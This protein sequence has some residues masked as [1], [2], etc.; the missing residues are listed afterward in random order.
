VISQL[1]FPLM[2]CGVF[3]SLCQELVHDCSVNKIPFP[4]LE[5]FE[6]RIT[7]PK[8]YFLFF[9]V[10]VRAGRHNREL[11]KK[12]IKDNKGRNDKRFGPAIF[13]AHVRTTVHENYFKWI[14]QQLSDIHDV[15]DQ[16]VEDFKMEYDEEIYTDLPR[17]LVCNHK[18]LTRFPFK[19]CEISYGETSVPRPDAA[20]E[21]EVEDF[22]DNDS[23]CSANGAVDEP[24]TRVSTRVLQ[25]VSPEPGKEK[26][27]FLVYKNVDDKLFEEIRE[28][29]RKNIKLT[30][31][32]TVKQHSSVLKNFK[33]TVMKIRH[34]KKTLPDT[35]PMYKMAI[36]EAKRELRLFK[37]QYEEDI[38]GHSLRKRRRK[39]IEN[40]TRYS[41]SKITFFSEANELMKQEEKSGLRQSWEKIYKEIWNKHLMV[42]KNPV[43]S[44]PMPQVTSMIRD[45][46][47]DVNQ[48]LVDCAENVEEV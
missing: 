22:D 36:A 15:D 46:E 20:P 14:F 23:F 10:F 13:E 12:A 45:M 29:Q 42:P 27:F 24:A 43:I 44:I 30:I 11:W 21:E 35:D 26:Q 48:L 40:Q 4:A 2:W 7:F 8:R 28:Q 32:M 47:D 34:V 25:T 37:D 31:E 5:T 41:D 17:K 18:E 6:D 39:S 19:N 33:Q 3:A 16:Q 1:C 38:A 9:D